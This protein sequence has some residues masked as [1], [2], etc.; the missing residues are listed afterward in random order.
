ME[1]IG[2]VDDDDDDD[3]INFAKSFN[4]TSSYLIHVLATD[5]SKNKVCKYDKYF[6]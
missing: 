6:K 1:Y 5:C 2:W 4:K 3:E